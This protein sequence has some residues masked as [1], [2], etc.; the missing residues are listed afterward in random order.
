MPQRTE[1]R[2][3]GA[4]TA[5]KESAPAV[6]AVMHHHKDC[7]LGLARV[8]RQLDPHEAQTQVLTI[9]TLAVELETAPDCCPHGWWSGAVLSLTRD[10][11]PALG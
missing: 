6:L 8:C 7:N 1:P 9:S 10:S 11:I 2:S 3:L 5:C 4:V